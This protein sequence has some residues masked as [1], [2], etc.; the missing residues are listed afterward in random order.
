VRQRLQESLRGRGA[1]RRFKDLA[2]EIGLLDGWYAYRDERYEA[3]ARAWCEEN[4]FV[5][6]APEA[7]A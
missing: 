5:V 2:G 6:A 1:F 7:D 3:L 4:G